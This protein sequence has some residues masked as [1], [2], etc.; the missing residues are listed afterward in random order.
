[1]FGWSRRLSRFTSWRVLTL[2][3]SSLMISKDRTWLVVLS[4]T[5]YSYPIF[6]FVILASTLYSEH[7]CFSLI[8]RKSPLILTELF[9]P[10]PLTDFVFMKIFS[11]SLKGKVAYSKLLLIMVD[12]SHKDAG[13]SWFWNARKMLSWVFSLRVLG[14][15]NLSVSKLSNLVYESSKSS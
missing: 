5:L 8:L 6:L 10:F 9:L 2:A 11:F 4:M 13:F 15:L 12:S 3:W 14:W 1:M 7:A